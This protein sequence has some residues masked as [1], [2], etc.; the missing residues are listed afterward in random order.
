[1]SLTAFSQPAALWV[2]LFSQIVNVKSSQFANDGLVERVQLIGP[3]VQS[4]VSGSASF[5]VIELQ[6]LINLVDSTIDRAEKQYTN[7]MLVSLRDENYQT[8]LNL[9]V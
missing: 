3:F 1:M 4:G 9:L 7:K 2:N 6:Q 8:M 5:L